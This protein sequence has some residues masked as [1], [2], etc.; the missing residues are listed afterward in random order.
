MNSV[1]KKMNKPYVVKVLFDQHVIPNYRVGP[2]K[3]LA[4]K[5]DIDLT[6]SF[7]IDKFTD[8]QVV[9]ISDAKLSMTCNIE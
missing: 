1:L 7:W 8:H 3:K 2:F 5:N 4:N 6:V 9:E